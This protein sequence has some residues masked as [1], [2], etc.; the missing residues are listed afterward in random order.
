M[1]VLTRIAACSICCWLFLATT[2]GTV[3]C[4]EKLVSI[5]LTGNLE[6]Y[7]VVHQAFIQRLQQD[8]VTVYTQTPN[9]D[10]TSLANSIRKAVAI[11]SDLVI[12]Y[13][14]M[15]AMAAKRET[16]SVPVL[17]AD[18][19]DP[20]SLGLIK[21]IENGS[22]DVS[23]VSASTPLKTLLKTLADLA[24]LNRTIAALYSSNDP[25]SALQCSLLEDL[26]GSYDFKIEPFDLTS[27]KGVDRAL[28]Q[29]SEREVLL[30]VSE[31]ALIQQQL[32]QILSFA[33]NRHLMVISQVPG[34]CDKGALLTLEPEL[35]E[36]G[37][38][39]ADY[40]NQVLNGTLI[41][42]LPVIT[43]HKVDLV[44]NLTVAREHKLDVS[45]Q[46]LNRATRVIKTTTLSEQV[47]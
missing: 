10:P 11:D 32:E 1:T 6:R 29:L 28:Y 18:V 20:V 17:F 44:L 14:A 3:A 39:L 36:Q 23:G 35:E 25:G 27:V 42:S 40:A 33:K 30:F 16:D 13:G 8:Q 7:Q 5:V 19:Y 9:P 15:A 4:G 43:P 12:T 34:L 24:P 46:T 26:A 45:L 21:C 41:S 2:A 38:M 31:S 22:C 37:V 47:Q